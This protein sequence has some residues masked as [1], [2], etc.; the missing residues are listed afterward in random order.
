MGVTSIEW[1]DRVWNPVTGCTKVSHGCKHCY[2]EVMAKRTFGRLYPPVYI[3]PGC[4]EPADEWRARRFT[5]VQCHPDRLDAPLKWRKPSR[6]FVNSMS[7]LFHESVPDSFIDRVFAVMALAPQHTFLV[8]T[9]RPERMRAYFDPYR[10]QRV[11][12]AGEQMRPSRPPAHWYHVS[13]WS[14]RTSPWP[15]HN[16]WLGV[17]VEDQATADQRIP[18]LLQTP[19]AVRWVSYEPALDRVRFHAIR[20]ETEGSGG[21]AYVDVLNGTF[22]TIGGSGL[23]GP[24]LDWVVVGGESGPKART[25]DV[26]WIRAVV[27]QC[28]SASVPVFVKQLGA[29]CGYAPDYGEWFQGYASKSAEEVGYRGVRRLVDRKGGNPDE[30]P[31]DLRVR[32]FPAVRA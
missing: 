8:L 5:D 14:C 18:I 29:N 28:R 21:P 17:S 25:C 32:Q 7:D 16:V 19:A 23:K 10:R 13:D 27:D 24:R 11:I 26:A 4:D 9:K 31:A 12:D 1:A 20:W 6:I 22:C 15:L 30:W 2:A 3:G